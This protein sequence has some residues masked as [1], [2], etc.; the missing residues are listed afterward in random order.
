MI[1]HIFLYWLR[2]I[3]IYINGWTKL[4][5]YLPKM[6]FDGCLTCLVDQNNFEK[7]PNK[8]TILGGGGRGGPTELVKDHTLTFFFFL[9]PSLRVTSTVQPLLTGSS[10]LAVAL[11]MQDI[12]HT[13]T[14]TWQSSCV[15]WDNPLLSLDTQVTSRHSGYS[16]NS[17]LVTYQLTSAVTSCH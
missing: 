15:T 17:L 9:T 7:I 14:V 12:S 3:K 4:L 16:D 10:A 1:C 2:L 6:C 13:D 8:K 11:P 5:F